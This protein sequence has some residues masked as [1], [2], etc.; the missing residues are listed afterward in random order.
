MTDMDEAV[1]KAVALA[2]STDGAAGA[3]AGA[4]K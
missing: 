4:S 3:A 2:T 1:K